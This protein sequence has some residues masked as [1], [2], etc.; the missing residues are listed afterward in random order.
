MMLG[1]GPLAKVE[2]GCIHRS[3]RVEHVVKVV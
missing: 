1:Q 2:Q 3:A